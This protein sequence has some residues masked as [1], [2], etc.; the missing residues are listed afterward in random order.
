MKVYKYIYDPAA[1]VI[2]MEFVKKREGKHLY[3]DIDLFDI[4]LYYDEK[5]KLVGM[6]HL[7]FIKD[8]EKGEIKRELKMLLPK[9]RWRD[10]VKIYKKVKSGI[11][12]DRRKWFNIFWW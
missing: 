1:D 6:E 8:Y 10:I 3:G 11:K 9:L 12:K 4:V 2:Y 7:E 5:H